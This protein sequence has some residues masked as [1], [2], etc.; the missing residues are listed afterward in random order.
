M[1]RKKGTFVNIGGVPVDLNAGMIEAVTNPPLGFVSKH[2]FQTTDLY[3]RARK[4]DWFSNCGSRLSADLTMGINSVDSWSAA[5]NECESDNWETATL[6]ARNQLTIF[7]SKHYRDKY[8]S[9]NDVSREH[10]ETLVNPL[11]DD[12]R[13]SRES[14][15]NLEA[16]DVVNPISA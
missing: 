7:L 8:R 3:A 16:V 10:K 6:E 12:H 13:P 15:E 9:W 2:K 4:I 5:M 1:T 11:V 14:V